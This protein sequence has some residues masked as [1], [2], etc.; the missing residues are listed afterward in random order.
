M[1]GVAGNVRVGA[2]GVDSGVE[3]DSV[4]IVSVVNDGAVHEA[5]RFLPGR[6]QIPWHLV[7]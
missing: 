2:G 5:G 4:V 1:G 3:D 6:R 7:P